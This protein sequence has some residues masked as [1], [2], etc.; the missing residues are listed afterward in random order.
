[1]LVYFKLNVKKGQFELTDVGCELERWMKISDLI[2]KILQFKATTLCSSDYVIN[3]ALVLLRYKA[4]LRGAD[5]FFYVPDKQRGVIGPHS[6][7]HGNSTNLAVML[8]GLQALAFFVDQRT[9]KEH[10]PWC[11]W[12][13]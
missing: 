2:D 6:T 13:S 3:V 11:A 9:V 10:T 5:P 7:A 8:V 12:G 1:M 4:S